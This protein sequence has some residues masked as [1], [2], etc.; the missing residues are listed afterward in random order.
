MEHAKQIQFSLRSKAFKQK[1]N[2]KI[3][4]ILRMVFQSD[5]VSN[6]NRI[7][8]FILFHTHTHT[9]PYTHTQYNKHTKLESS[10]VNTIQYK[11]IHFYIFGSVVPLKCTHIHRLCVDS[12]IHSH[13]LNDSHARLRCVF[14]HLAWQ[15]CVKSRSSSAQHSTANQ[16]IRA[17]IMTQS[18]IHAHTMPS[19][20]LLV[21]VFIHTIRFSLFSLSLSLFGLTLCVYIV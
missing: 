3:E 1:P 11:T 14:F 18:K 2:A 9:R 13:K 20:W 6:F 17:H 12:L 15:H 7:P 16:N 4:S 8:Y 21:V 19:Q 10:S 5:V